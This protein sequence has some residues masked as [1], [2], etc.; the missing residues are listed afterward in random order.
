MPI[1]GEIGGENTRGELARVNFLRDE[2]GGGRFFVNDLNGPLYIL[3]KKSKQFTTYLDFNGLAGRPGLFAKFTFERNFATGLI[4]VLFDPDYSR[5]G[6]FYTIHMEDPTTAAPAEPKSGVVPGLDLS[7]YRTTPAIVTPT[8]PGAPINREAV[9]IEWTDRNI[10]NTT[11]EGTAREL[12]RMQLASPI[13]PLG[14]MTFNPIARRGDPDW[15]VMYIGAGDSGTGE[16]RDIRRLNPQRLDNLCGKILRIVPDLREHTANEHGERERALSHP[17][18]QPLRLRR[19][20]A[21]RR[22]GRWACAIPIDW[23]G[24]SI[25]RN[26]A[27]RVC[28][29]STSD[30]P[31]G[32]RS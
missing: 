14:E 1:T 27:S 9:V 8:A 25:P 16:Q 10:R 23:S 24:T 30:S 2:P 17:E 22:S 15:R 12:L 7:A 26:P 13:H 11:F 6:V 5:N 21:Q 19:R 32:R 3:D 28:S 4:N 31:G 29:R 20:R 18:R